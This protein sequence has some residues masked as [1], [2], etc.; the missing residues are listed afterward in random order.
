MFVLNAPVGVDGVFSLSD[1]FL[2]KRGGILETPGHYA[3]LVH[4]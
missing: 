2:E 3:D 1:N 4:M